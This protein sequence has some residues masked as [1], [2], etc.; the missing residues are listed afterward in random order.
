MPRELTGCVEYVP[1]EPG[2]QLGHYRY[3]ISLVDGSRPWIDIAP[4]ARSKDAEGRV[5]EVAAERS[6]TAREKGLRAEDFGLKPR[7]SKAAPPA[8]TAGTIM[9][10]WVDTWTKHRQER[11]L[12]TARECAGVWRRH[13]E[14][15]I[16]A[17]VRDW[18]RDDLRRLARTLDER[19]Q[20][21]EL[22]WKSARNIWVIATKIAADAAGSKLD[23]IRCRA[24]NPAIGVEGPDRGARKAK[25]F[26][27]PSEFKRFVSCIDVPVAWRRAVALAIYTFV[28]DGELRALRWGAGDVDLEHGVLSVTRALRRVRLEPVRKGEPARFATVPTKTGETRRFAIEATLLPLLKA[29]HG[30]AG[31][32][33][34]LVVLPVDHHA[35]SLR[36]AT[37]RDLTSARQPQVNGK[38]AGEKLEGFARRVEQVRPTSMPTHRKDR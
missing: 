23:T 38:F 36:H 6:K 4:T 2:E 27:F 12:A 8:A 30:E 16:A 35:H 31:G 29:M 24:D 18:T 14:P 25:Q 34:P 5:R 28:R 17:H 9:S 20:K 11:G 1:P 33:G 22:S 7:G 37:S 3:R 32:E 10:D 15:V 13:I 21:S 19:V 26:L